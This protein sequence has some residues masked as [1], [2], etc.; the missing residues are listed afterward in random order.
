MSEIQKNGDM[1]SQSEIIEKYGLPKAALDRYLPKPSVKSGRSRKGKWFYSRSWNRSDV[2]A[3]LQLPEVKEL[4]EQKKKQEQAEILREEIRSILSAYN[5]ENLVE[6]AKEL[7]RVFVLHVGPT[8]SGKTY[9]AVKSLK[10]SGCGV[11]L[12]PLRLLA[13]EM[14][15]RMNR[16]QVKCSLLTGEEYIPEDGAEIVSSTIELCDFHKHYKVAV[17]DEAQLITDGY[18]GAAW[19]QAICRVNADEVHIC[20]A[21]EALPVIESLVKEFGDPYNIVMHERLVPLVYSGRCRSYKDI[22][23]NDAVICFSR[24]NVLSTAALLERNGFKA[25]IIYGALP[26]V[27]RRNEVERYLKGE[28]NVIVATDAIGMGISLPIRRVIF[29]EAQKFDGRIQ[30]RLTPAEVKQVAGRAGRYGMF[31]LG[32]VLTMDSTDTVSRGLSVQVRSAGSLCIS[33]PRDLLATDY[34]IDE[35]MRIW[36]NLPESKSF[37]REDMKE[38]I[39]LFSVLKPL[40]KDDKNRELVFDLITCPVD[41]GNRELVRY[42]FDCTRAILKNKKSIPKPPFGTETL[43]DCELQYKAYDIY[44]QL[45]MRIGKEDDT[46]SEKDNI[47]QRIKELMQQDKSSYI[48]KCKICGR[49]LPLGAHFDICESC[50]KQ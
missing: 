29:A 11:Y 46:S 12:G 7:K 13:L 18:R 28:T 10:E 32:E 24:K 43:M 41:T 23:P 48:R 47:C 38:A 33:F 1:V 31:D 3:A 5:P 45:H 22:Q 16:E 34:P 14:Y 19:F 30:R 36:Q 9:Q 40:L 25:S 4:I 15:D 6:K 35:L 20:L 26:P 27:A 49:E 8:N 44:H 50:Y 42:W 17:I 39:I 2:E 37:L 21:P